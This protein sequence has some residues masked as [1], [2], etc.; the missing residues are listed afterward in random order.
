MG[1]ERLNVKVSV[2]VNPSVQVLEMS[3]VM[4]PVAVAGSVWVNVADWKGVPGELAMLKVVLLRV[5]RP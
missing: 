2:T 5:D 3:I 1:R 4:S